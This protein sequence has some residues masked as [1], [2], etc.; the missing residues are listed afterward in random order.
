MFFIYTKLASRAFLFKGSAH[1]AGPSRIHRG[2][3]CFVSEGS[4]RFEGSEGS[5]GLNGL[6]GLRGLKGLK[7]LKGLRVRR[8][9]EVCVQGLIST[10]QRFRKTS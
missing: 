3:V 2:T 8:V 5:G 6:K 7:G 9:Q 4:E 10:A 1:S